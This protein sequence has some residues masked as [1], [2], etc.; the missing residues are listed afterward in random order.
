[1][2]YKDIIC[3]LFSNE[4]ERYIPDGLA[5]SEAVCSIDD[6]RVLDN[7]FLYSVSSDRKKARAPLAKLVIDLEKGTVVDYMEFSDFGTILLNNKNSEEAI[8][9]ALD[10]Y[11]ELYPQFRC[12]FLNGIQTFEDKQLV[13]KIWNAL[14]T[15]ANDEF[16]DI[17]ENISPHMFKF[18]KKNLN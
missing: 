13:F 5:Y 4:N 18:I 2:I 12:V 7:I 1:M 16:L 14:N 9:G 11:E 17:Y 10:L 3:A 15:F 8:I 6:S